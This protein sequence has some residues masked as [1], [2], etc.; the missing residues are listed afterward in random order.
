[1]KLTN[2][3]KHLPTSQRKVLHKLYIEGMSPA[4]AAMALSMSI[5]TIEELNQQGLERLRSIWE[6]TT[7]RQEKEAGLGQ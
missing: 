6:E 5:T 4:A 2:H 7:C 1:M 3:I